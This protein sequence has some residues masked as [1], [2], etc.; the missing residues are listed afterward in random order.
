MRKHNQI[1]KSPG[2]FSQQRQK[3]LT[4]ATINRH[5]NTS[6]WSRN[7]TG[8]ALIQALPSVIP[9]EKSVIDLGAGDGVFLR[10]L[11]DLGYNI[12]GL[13]GSLN[14]DKITGGLVQWADLTG[15]CS[16]HYGSADWGLFIE[17][18]EHVPKE[19][20][21][22]LFDQ[23]SRIP[24]EGLVVSWAGVNQTG[25]HHV[26]CQGFQYVACEFFRRGWIMDA[27]STKMIRCFGRK[28]N[29]NSRFV[30]RR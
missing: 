13:D 24:L 4:S 1:E 30:L 2:A 11:R 9:I 28:H 19:Y 3:K 18:G 15:D 27:E 14:I 22:A 6:D 17:V 5:N 16:V 8:R 10:S 25:W 20:E 23:V 29:R 21:Q 7:K 12:T 26:N